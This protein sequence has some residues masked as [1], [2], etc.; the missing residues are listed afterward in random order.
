MSP[1]VCLPTCKH[2]KDQLTIYKTTEQF[3]VYNNHPDKRFQPMIGQLSVAINDYIDSSQKRSFSTS[4]IN[5]DCCYNEFPGNL[6]AVDRELWHLNCLFE[7]WKETASCQLRHGR[8]HFSWPACAQPVCSCAI[9]WRGCKET[10]ILSLK[11]FLCQ[12]QLCEV[13]RFLSV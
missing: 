7:T 1:R 8:S 3:Q 10:N 2:I 4:L 9:G 13:N 11:R 6:P 12:S 5:S